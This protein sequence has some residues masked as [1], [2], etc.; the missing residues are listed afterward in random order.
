MPERSDNSGIRISGGNITGESVAIGSGAT[1]FSRSEAPA[2]DPS[3]TDW[4]FALALRERLTETFERE[5]R[6]LGVVLRM[7]AEAAASLPGAQTA[8]SGQ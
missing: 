2:E 8:R 4:E 5:R 3:R 6:E 7:E 1:V